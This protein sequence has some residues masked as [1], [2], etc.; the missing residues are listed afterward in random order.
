MKSEL[1]A[2]DKRSEAK[3]KKQNYIA[4]G[5]DL[6]ANHFD[7]CT[8]FFFFRLLLFFFRGLNRFSFCLGV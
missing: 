8:N 6:A 4:T 2:Q 3:K 5:R 7:L 1:Y